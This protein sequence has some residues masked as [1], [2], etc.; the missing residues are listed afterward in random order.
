MNNP[1]NRCQEVVIC[2]DTKGSMEKK[3]KGDA[4]KDR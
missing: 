2:K 3:G 4:L 1:D